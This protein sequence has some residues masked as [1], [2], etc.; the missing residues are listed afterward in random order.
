MELVGSVFAGGHEPGDFAWMITLPEYDDAL[1]IFNDNEEEFH[2]HQ[3]HAPGSG[4][5]PNRAGSRWLADDGPFGDS[6]APP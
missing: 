4:R 5:L 1:F 6:L 3:S 2:A